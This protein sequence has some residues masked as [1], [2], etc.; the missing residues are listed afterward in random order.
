[1]FEVTAGR[2]ASWVDGELVGGF[3]TTKVTGV[4]VDSRTIKPGEIFIPLKGEFTDGHEHIVRAVEAG[5]TGFLTEKLNGE[6]KRAISSR[7]FAIKVNDSIGALQRLAAAYRG[8]L[9]AKVVGIT[10]STGKTTA[11]EMATAILRRRLSVVASEKNYNNEI[12]LPL[13]LLGAS[14]ETEVIIVEMAM[15]GLGQI[16][17]LTEI[18]KPDIGLVTGVGKSHI[19]LLGTAEAIAEAKAELVKG[20]PSSGIAILNADNGWTPMLVKKTSA[21]VRTYGLCDADLVADRIT[22]DSLGRPSFRIKGERFLAAVSLPVPGRHNVYNALAA[23]SIALALGLGADEIAG[24]LSEVRLP[25]MRM[26]VSRAGEVVILND[27]YNANPDSM[28]AAIAVLADVKTKGRRIIVLGDMLE[29]GPIAEESHLAVGRNAAK[30]GVDLL[31]TVG[32]LGRLI[33]EGAREGGM[34]D[35]AII[36]FDSA[37]DAG[38][39]VAEFIEPKD[40]V[41]VKASRGMKLEQVA[42]A[43]IRATRRSIY[44]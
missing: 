19:E 29:L 18:A 26:E 15:R 43:I 33:A 41:L 35:G 28:L 16:A 23:A 32:E 8:I 3:L 38:R 36:S 27:A 9:S 5:A 24:G 39:N 37:E 20:L 1:M 7:A 13:T 10:G 11:R 6:A 14:P 42:D 2:L 31:V 22:V 17:A 12:G 4:S 30:T 40:V 21:S 34:A 25:E 44:R